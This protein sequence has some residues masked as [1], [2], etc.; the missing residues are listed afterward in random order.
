[1][2]PVNIR[3]RNM[4]GGRSSSESSVDNNCR[5]C[6]RPVKSEVKCVKCGSLYHPSC[7]VRVKGVKVVGY[8]ELLCNG[9]NVVDDEEKC[10][11]EE[12]YDHLTKENDLLNNL[13][14]QIMDNNGLLRENNYLLEEKL[15]SLTSEYESLKKNCVFFAADVHSNQ[16]RVFGG[17]VNLNFNAPDSPTRSR[18]ATY[19]SAV[20]GSV[21]GS[22]N[23][24]PSAAGI[25]EDPSAVGNSAESNDVAAAQVDF[26][27][28][29]GSQRQRGGRS[30]LVGQPLKKDGSLH[31]QAPMTVGVKKAGHVNKRRDFNRDRDKFISKNRDVLE[32]ARA[33]LKPVERSTWIYISNLH[34]ETTVEDVIDVLKEVD[35][36]ANFEVERREVAKG[37]KCSFIIKAPLKYE[38][39]LRDVGFWPAEVYVNRY[40]FPKEKTNFSNAQQQAAAT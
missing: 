20:A 22:D 39:T 25:V 14:L 8:N 13:L 2:I 33:K 16:D 40:Y 1:M 4:A 34:L 36:S 5:N 12:K 9:C 6:A 37:R 3:L 38:D 32:G 18:P 7:V 11:L 29:A 24:R 31:G 19:A 27:G 10:S 35:E 26:V 30:V 21:K 23:G 28:H 17:N 15:M